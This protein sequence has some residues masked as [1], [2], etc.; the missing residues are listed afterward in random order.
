MLRNITQA[1]GLGR[2]LWLS[3]SVWEPETGFCEHN[4][5]TSDYIKERGIF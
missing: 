1:L 2:V 4:N 5:E 3:D